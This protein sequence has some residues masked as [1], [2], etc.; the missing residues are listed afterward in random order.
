MFAGHLAVIT[1]VDDHRVSKLPRCLEGVDKH[2]HLV[3][4]VG[5]QGVV[6]VPCTPHLVIGEVGEAEGTP[7]PLHHWW[8]GG[9]VT[10]RDDWQVDG[11]GV[12]EIPVRLRCDQGEMWR[13]VPHVHRPGLFTAGSIGN[14]AHRGFSYPVVD[15][16]FARTTRSGLRDAWPGVRGYRHPLRPVGLPV[17]L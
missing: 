5:A 16:K 4:K 13:D 6:A 10:F 2:P 12:V 15:I 3:I 1:R 9:E 17:R 14:V 7:H 11:T 8:Q